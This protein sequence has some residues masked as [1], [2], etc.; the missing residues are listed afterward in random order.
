MDEAVAEVFQ[1]MLQRSCRPGNQPSAIPAD[2][3]ACVSF[4]GAL[5]ALCAVEFP[6]ASAQQLAIAL[7]GPGEWDAAMLADAVGELCNMIAG[8]WKR[9]LGAPGWE[10]N[11]SVPSVSRAPANSCPASW[12]PCIRRTYTF[13]NSQFVV[14]VSK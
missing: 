4:S 10:A 11:L 13:D 5:E 3:F 9:R 12:Q 2:I 7:L 6:L 8:G 1:S 14:K